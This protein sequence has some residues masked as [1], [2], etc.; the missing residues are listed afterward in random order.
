MN[1]RSSEP[2]APFTHVCKFFAHAGMTTP[3]KYDS[4]AYQPGYCACAT[5][6]RFALQNLCFRALQTMPTF[7]VSYAFSF[8][9]P[10][11]YRYRT[12]CT[13]CLLATRF[14]REIMKRWRLSVRGQ[15]Y[16]D[17]LTN[18]VP[19]VKLI[20]KESQWISPDSHLILDTYI[21]LHNDRMA[22]FSS[23]TLLIT[24]QWL[25]K[26]GVEAFCACAK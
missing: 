25:E 1:G 23:G 21:P 20:H 13:V 11:A 4:F 12:Y 3:L 22:I 8:A 5:F 26:R 14:R 19:S 7:L 2:P 6:W 16:R 18:R 10:F 9:A 17:V 15:T 24:W